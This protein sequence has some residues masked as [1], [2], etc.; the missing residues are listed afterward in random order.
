MWLYYEYVLKYIKKHPIMHVYAPQNICQNPACT[1]ILPLFKKALTMRVDIKIVLN[2]S[3]YLLL[4]VLLMRYGRIG[5]QEK[6]YNT[7]V[8]MYRHSMQFAMLYYNQTR[9][10]M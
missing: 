6:P 4:T 7:Y 3:T 8:F 9:T 1:P 10:F 2:T 5:V